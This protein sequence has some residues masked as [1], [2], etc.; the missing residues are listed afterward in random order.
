MGTNPNGSMYLYSYHTALNLNRNVL[1]RNNMHSY[2]EEYSIYRK[3][4]TSFGQQQKT[5]HC[6][7]TPHHGL[8][9]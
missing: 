7:R 4:H 3:G 1:I 6:A 8:F 9:P 2:S 5:A